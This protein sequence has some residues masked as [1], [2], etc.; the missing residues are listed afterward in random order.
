MADAGPGTVGLID[1]ITG[2]LGVA[3]TVL[4]LALGVAKILGTGGMRNCSSA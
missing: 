1:G 4:S 2:T 3:S